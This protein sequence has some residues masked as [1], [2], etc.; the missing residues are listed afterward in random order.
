MQIKVFGK[1]GCKY[2]KT[3]MEKFQTFLKRWGIDEKVD[4]SFFD[5][6]KNME[7]MAEG[8]FYSVS[9]IPATVI[10]KEG[11]MLARWDG[12]VPISKDFEP[13]FESLRVN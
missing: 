6:E 10:E 8:A 4:L 5:M 11:T 2:C 9:K 1:D 3:T 13:F 7:G 12:E